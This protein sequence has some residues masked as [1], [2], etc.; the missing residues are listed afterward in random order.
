VNSSKQPVLTASGVSVR[1][2]GRGEF[3]LQ[4]ASLCLRPGE[5]VAVLGPSGGGKTTLL[6]ALEGSVACCR[7]T[8]EREGLAALVYQ[9]LRLVPEQTAL[10][11]VC[12]GALGEMR[13]SGSL[14]RYP[15]PIVQ[16]AQQ[17]LDD[18]GLADLAGKRVGQLSGGQRQ[19]VAIARALCARP[20]VLLAD[21]PLSALDPE[22]ASRI[23]RLL[24]RLQ[25]KYQ[26]A[27]VLSL[28]APGPY[29]DFFHRYLLVREGRIALETDSHETAWRGAF[30]VSEQEETAPDAN[31]APLEPKQ[32]R[33]LLRAPSPAMRMARGALALLVVAVLLLWSAWS[34]GLNASSFAGAGGAVWGFLARILPSSPAAA[35]SLPWKE[36]FLSL[37]ETIQMAILGTTVGIVLSLPMAVMASRQTS[38][39][40]IRMPARLLL[41][42]VRTIPS[43]FWGLIFVAFV[44][45]GPLA[46][47]F[48]LAAYSVGYLTKFF[49]EGLEDVDSRAGAALRSL[50]ATRFQVFTQAVFPAARPVLVAACLFVFEYNIRSASILGVVGAGGIGQDLMYYIEWRDFTSAAAG[51]AMILVVVVFLDS[52]SELWRRRLVKDRG[53]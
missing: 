44:G 14:F 13:R 1:Y 18:L 6:R 51:L 21:E 31:D 37:V 15:R 48:A 40:P 43:I 20:K 17:L 41:N 4:D 16:R 50:G 46:G 52:I 24:A 33:V 22:N 27:L 42:L 34:L 10:R 35:A 23:V 12:S 29:P 53:T 36:L 30:G 19:R 8:V 45:L 47:V 32:D 49:Y 5:R 25:S 39:W 9:D 3:A 7:G 26:F 11:N 28:H 2:D 38:P